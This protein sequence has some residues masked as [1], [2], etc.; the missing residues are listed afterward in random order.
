[1]IRIS[2]KAIVV[3]TSPQLVVKHEQKGL[4]T[5]N[6]VQPCWQPREDVFSVG[7]MQQDYLL[8]LLRLQI[9]ELQATERI[10]LC[11]VELAF[12]S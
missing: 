6:F 1:M 12:H 3:A 11:I 8:L 5:Q 2:Q 9:S 4:V 7:N 10:Q